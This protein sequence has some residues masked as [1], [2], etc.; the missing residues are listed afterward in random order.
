MFQVERYPPDTLRLPGSVVAVGAFDGLHL[1]HQ[2][3]LRGAVRRARERRV[4]TVVYTF[5]PPPRAHFAGAR[6]LTPLDEKLQRL[7]A[8]GVS[9]A[10]VAPFDDHYA[11]RAP[12]TL[13]DELQQLGA[14]EVWVGEGFRFGA[15]RSGDI[16]LLKHSVAVHV[17]PTVLCSNQLPIS[18]SRVRELLANHAYDRAGELL[19]RPAEA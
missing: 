10:V 11:R 12:D 1:G 16:E 19:G 13:I 6:I 5:D 9:H 17:H 3:L 18:S 7:A 2:T 4:P 8:L 15:R 14:E